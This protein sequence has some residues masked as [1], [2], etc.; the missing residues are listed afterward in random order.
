L[1]KIDTK[2]RRTKST[3]SASGTAVVTSNGLSAAHLIPSTLITIPLAFQAET[4]PLIPRRFFVI[5]SMR[6]V[7]NKFSFLDKL[8]GYLIAAVIRV[9]DTTVSLCREVTKGYCR[10]VQLPLENKR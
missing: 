2:E 10:Q 6:P 7:F 5:V 4:H 3:S 1:K 8:F 9:A